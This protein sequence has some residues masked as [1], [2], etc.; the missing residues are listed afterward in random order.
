MEYFYKKASSEDLERIW[1]KNI[2]ANRGDKR[3]KIWKKEMLADNLANRA[4]TFVVLRGNDPVG[5]G[6]LLFSP[7]C[8]AI[9]GRKTLCDGRTTA[10]INALR[11]EKAFENQGHISKL[12]HQMEVYAAECG[13]DYLTIGVEAKETRN[14]GIYLH[15]GYAEFVMSEGEDGELVLYYRKKL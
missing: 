15:W 6:T 8:Q 10:N 2:A 5:E 3:W 13:Y 14:L 7:A 1:E 4:S 11:I 9:R 12:V